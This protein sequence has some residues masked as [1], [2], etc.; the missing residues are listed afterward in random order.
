MLLFSLLCCIEQ[1]VVFNIRL[2]QMILDKKLKGILDQ[3]NGCL[4]LFLEQ[5]PD[6]QNSHSHTNRFIC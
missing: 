2:S 5:P 3:G 4:I 1:N 6:V